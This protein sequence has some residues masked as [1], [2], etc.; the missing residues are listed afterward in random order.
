[1]YHIPKFFFAFLFLIVNAQ[2]QQHIGQWKSFTDMKS[3]RSAVLVGNSIWAATGG[4]VF[5]LDTTNGSFTKFTNIDGLDTNDVLTINFDGTHYIWVGGA[6]G[7]VNVYDINTNQWQTIVDIANRTES[8]HKNIQSFSFKGDTVFIVT[9]FGVSVFKRSRWE[10]GDTYQ[11]LGF[12]SPQVSCMALQQNRIWIGT[13]KGLTVSFLGSGVWTQYIS[14]PGIISSAVTALTVFNDTLIVGTAN[15]AVYFALNDITPKAVPLLSN[16]YL[17]ELRVYNGKL[18]VLS[19]SGSN[20][21]VEALTSILDMP[22]TV[23]SNSEVQGVCIIPTSSLWIATASKGLAHLVGSIWNYSYPSGP[24]S[25]F[26][27]SL[28]VDADG[29]LWCASGETAH[30]G[31]YRYNPSLTDDK[32]WKNFTSQY[33]T[34]MRKYNSSNNNY[35]PFDD[36]YKISLG[37]NG[38]IWVSSWGDGVVEVVGDSV[39]RKYNYYSTPSLPGAK[40]GFPDYVVT[41]GVALDSQGKVWI[42]NRNESNGRSLLRLDSDTTGTF[43]NNQLTSWGW[44]HGVVIDQ[45]DTKW[46]GSTVPWHMDNGQGLYFFNEKNIISGTELNGGWGNIS[47]MPDNRVLSISLDLEGEIWVGLGL[48]IVIIPDPLN[49]TY[50]N[51]SFPLRE[52][53]IQSIAVDALNNKWIGTKEG[54]FVVNT[55]GTQL[56]QSFT[57]ASTNKSLLSND[58]RTISIDQKRGIA[59]FGTEQG[60]SSLAIAA[61]QTNRTYSELECGPNPFILPNDQ[62]LTIRNL[63]TNSTIKI[64][65]VSGSVVRQFEAQGGGRA[66]WDGRDKSGAF[67]ASGIYFIFASAENSSQTITGKVAVIRK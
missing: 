34:I 37:A 35:E 41:S 27:S 30:A 47:D 31:F 4:G 20:F 14:F 64:L 44:F 24:N 61:V 15:G 66:F 39:K 9:E 40:T 53:V 2:S 3:V 55:D 65:T 50:R 33:N 8:T 11:N 28:A 52:Q 38:S 6:G 18:Y 5:T 1:M 42:V 17:S 67:V 59:Y 56:L 16:R 21:T 32:Q 23:A 58:V 12:I 29:M 48:G 13:D 46:M 36:F 45:N 25:N 7:W 62:P 26:F 57:V 54:I 43:F 49:P 19:T 51:T 63:V 60:L 10:F 22:Q